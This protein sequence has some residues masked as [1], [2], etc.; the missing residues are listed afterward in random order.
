MVTVGNGTKGTFSAVSS[1]VYTLVVTPTAAS[2]GNI[3]VNVSTTGVTDAAGNQATAPAQYIQAFDTLAPTLAISSDP[4]AVPA[5]GIAIITFTFS[6]TPAGFIADNIITSGGNLTGLA[7]TADPKVYTATFTADSSGTASISVVAGSYTDAAGNA[8]GASFY[9]AA[10]TLAIS[11]LG[12][13]DVLA[14][15]EGASANAVIS[16]IAFTATS[17]TSNA[18]TA[19]LT[20]M[21]YAVNLANATG[22]N[23]YDVI[24]TGA[25]TTFIGSAFSDR[26]IG[27]NGN[28][29]LVGGTLRDTLTGGAGADI[30]RFAAGDALIFG[31]ATSPI[32]ESITDL[33]IGTDAMDGPNALAVANVKQLGDVGASLTSTSIAALLTTSNF[34]TDGASTFTFGSGAGLR[35]FIALNDAT[36]GYQSSTD[37][38]IEITGYTGTLTDLAII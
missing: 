27:G 33:A 13:G 8:G 31:T 16:A 30:F 2:S 14:V 19:T 3:T 25:A 20:S 35:T 1:T 12:S 29:N 23:G 10:D 38:I 18:G 6:E 36:A 32:F 9:V 37:N 4:A 34:L 22:P 7:V 15:A 24:N 28:D 5:D 11:S 26:L 17:Q 21:G